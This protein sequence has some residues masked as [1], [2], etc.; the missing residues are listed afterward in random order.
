MH[1]EMTLLTSFVVINDSQDVDVHVTTVVSA[2]RTSGVHDT[3]GK[4]FVIV[5]LIRHIWDHGG[6]GR[7]PSI[8]R[9]K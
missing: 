2:D 1:Y 4:L 3:C 9:L 6:S 8:L 5:R 7:D